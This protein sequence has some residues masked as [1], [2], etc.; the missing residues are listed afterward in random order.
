[1]LLSYFEKRKTAAVTDKPEVP[2][3]YN[4][5]Q[6]ET[7]PDITVSG[8]SGSCK[9]RSLCSV[10]G[11]SAVRMRAPEPLRQT[12]PPYLILTESFSTLSQCALV[13]RDPLMSLRAERGNLR[14]QSPSYIPTSNLTHPTSKLSS[15]TKRSGVRR[16]TR[17]LRRIAPRNDILEVSNSSRPYLILTGCFGALSKCVLVLRDP[18]MS[19][20]AKRSEAW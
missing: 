2:P 8:D 14:P 19:L 17:L 18:L 3:V 15:R 16:S 13:L 6:S 9:A 7:I 5:K 20:R 4:C 1:M 12:A 10:A 11:T